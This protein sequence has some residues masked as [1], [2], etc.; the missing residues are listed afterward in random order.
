MGLVMWIIEDLQNTDVLH[1]RGTKLGSPPHS[2]VL[3]P[4]EM[5]D[6][7]YP[8]DIETHHLQETIVIW[9]QEDMSHHKPK[10]ATETHHLQETL[11]IWDQE[12]LSPHKPKAATETH[13]LQE[14]IVIWDQEDLNH[15]KPKAATETHH[16]QE[17]TVIWDQEDL[18]HHK[19]K[20]ATETHHLQET[21]VTWDQ[22]DLN[23]HKPKA[24]TE[25]RHH[26]DMIDPLQRAATE[27]HHR[28]HVSLRQFVRN[29]HPI[30]TMEV[31]QMQTGNQDETNQDEMRPHTVIT[32]LGLYCQSSH[33]KVN[34][35]TN[36]TSPR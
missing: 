5:K 36:K 8:R 4:A 34:L 24:A 29:Q 10:A 13:H 21:I 14:T 6:P 26:K 3:L 27:T 18:S 20:A 23:H 33:Q 1:Q 15:H 28:A 16:L 2:I 31:D 32:V 19:P 30:R 17:T 22:E 11:V 9:D 12:D 25:T 35:S 7:K